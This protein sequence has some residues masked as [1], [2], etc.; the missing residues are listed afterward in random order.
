[1]VVRLPHKKE[2]LGS[3]PSTATFSLPDTIRT[4]MC[5]LAFQAGRNRRAYREIN[6]ISFV[7]VY[8]TCYVVPYKDH[9]CSHAYPLHRR[10]ALP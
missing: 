10:R 1:M 7:I 5:P 4:C 3:I 2:C 9:I 8:D 6:F